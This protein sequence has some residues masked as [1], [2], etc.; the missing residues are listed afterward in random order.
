M[1]KRVFSYR[2]FSKL[3][4]RNK[5]YKQDYGRIIPTVIV[6]EVIGKD[7]AITRTLGMLFWVIMKIIT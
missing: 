2:N 7:G 5:S 4:F 6:L 1:Q 3:N